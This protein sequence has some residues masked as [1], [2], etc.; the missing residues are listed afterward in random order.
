MVRARVIIF[1]VFSLMILS[2]DFQECINMHR[3]YHEVSRY[4][5]KHRFTSVSKTFFHQSLPGSSRL[6][7]LSFDFEEECINMYLSCRIP[8][9]ELDSVHECMMNILVSMSLSFDFEK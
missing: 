5:G 2:F 7:T 9:Y 8:L 4:I 1:T 6:M 3:I